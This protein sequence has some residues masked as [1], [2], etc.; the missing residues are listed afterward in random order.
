MNFEF[1][2]FQESVHKM[3]FGTMPKALNVILEDDLVNTCKPGDD[4][5]I[6]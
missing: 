5:A 6:T 4:V 3:N 1:A 2:I